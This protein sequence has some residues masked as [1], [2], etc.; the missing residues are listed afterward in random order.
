MPRNTAV[1]RSKGQRANLAAIHARFGADA[2]VSS[3]PDPE[4][5]IE[6][7]QVSL[8]SVEK[9]LQATQADQCFTASALQKTQDQLQITQQKI[10]D[11][12]ITA[13]VERRKLQRAVVSKQKLQ[14]QIKLLKSADFS[15]D[16]KN[17]KQAINL[18]QG[19]TV[20]NT[21]LKS[22]LSQLLDKCSVEAQNS[23]SKQSELQAKLSN[24][25]AQL[26]TFK[27]RCDRMPDIQ[28]KAIKKA[29]DHAN[30][31]NKTHK[32]LHKG[33]YSP[34]A[35][36]LAR[37]LVA[38]GC[39]QDYVGRVI[40]T[41]CGAA[42]VTVKDHMSRR[43]VARSILEGQVAAQI[44]IG[45]ELAQT[46]GFTASGDGTSN[47]HIPYDARHIHINSGSEVGSDPKHQT[48]FLGLHSSVDQTSEQQVEDWKNI[49]SEILDVYQKS[50]LG[51]RSKGFLRHVEIL[52]KLKGMNSDHCSKEKKTARLME[53]EKHLA[54][55]EGLGED[56]MLDNDKE[57]DAVFAK[58][59]ADLIKDAGGIKTWAALTQIERSD[60]TAA[61]FKRVIISLGENSYSALSE[62]EQRDLDFFIWVGCGCHKDLNTV[63]GGNAAMMAWW[64][65]TGTIG[66]ILL[67]N[68]DNAAVLENKAPDADSAIA[69][70]TVEQRA[71]DN[72]TCG[73]VKV[74]S[75]AGAIF[76]HKDDKKG[77][78][79]TF[80]WWCQNHGIPSTF[81]DTS[82][83]RYGSHCDA[84]AVLIQYQ[85]KL[86]EFLDFVK[87]RKDKERF[88]NMESNLWKALQDMPTLTELSVLALY[89]QAV[90]HPYIQAIRGSDQKDLNMLDL[91]PLHIK[92]RAH[93]S[94]II[95][96][97]S[98]LLASTVTSASGAM[99]GKEWENPGVI[100]AILKLVPQLPHLSQVL[101]AFLKGA[102]VTWE[103]FTS[104]F[105]PGGLIDEATDLE[106]DLAWMPPTN[107]INEGVLGSY[108]VFMRY[109]P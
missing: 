16:G 32:L 6:A 25:R 45:H 43:T 67:A 24:T 19:A 76:N 72:T 65:E 66:P 10:A 54:V 11:L 46:K 108:R 82:N 33:I 81:P 49:L 79:H 58:A 93:I 4:P 71:L 62:Q 69:A 107:D 37:E 78:Q 77:Q 35:R 26:K 29:R 34:Q 87:L 7:L 1:K 51:I 44:Q 52:Q 39:S 2:D 109:K 97:P 106:K 59:K 61:M 100:T 56:Y 105:V 31:E 13:R 68:R 30:K 85:A 102:L 47:K 94:K 38:A 75:I 80:S 98:I 60:Q 89:A 70:T 50:P 92:V 9:E 5:T 55:L 90:S 57:T 15:I 8:V 104:E 84:A 86:L 23:K 22:Q 12:R 103:R 3:T 28:A 18:L 48:L 42:G 40:Q 83:T 88:T 64:K 99:D 63:R 91:G 73:G 14:E 53:K 36:Q 41:V 27:K 96:D 17:A 21:H 20:E 101:V 74:A 95:A